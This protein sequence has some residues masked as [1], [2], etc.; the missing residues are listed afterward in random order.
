MN[1]YSI[2]PVALCQGPRDASAWTYGRDMGKTV[3]SCCYIWYIEGSEPKVLVDCGCEAQAL[4]AK[5]LT[6]YDV[7]SVEE[8]LGKLGVKP[9]DI[10]IVILTHLHGD[11]VSLAWKYKNA[12][13]IIQKDEFDFALNPH[14]MVV[15]QRSYEDR[16]FEKLDAELVAGDEEIIDGVR[17][18]LTPGH[19]AG[20][21]SV[22]VDT[23]GGLAIISGLCTAYANFDP[24]PEAKAKGF[25]V[26]A[27]GRHLDALQAY[28]SLL[29]IKKMANIVIPLHDPAL[30]DIDRI[31]LE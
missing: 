26:I 27:P 4:V 21:Q 15:C 17:V 7:Q 25:E 18:L 14:P 30:M 9:D 28:D 22:A 29:R 1:K 23:D 11:H 24:A 19:S 31:P 20:G 12:R 3:G 8:G 6:E 10:G 13:F 2:R 16:I 5:G